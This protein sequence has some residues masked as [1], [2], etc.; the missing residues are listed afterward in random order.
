M[1]G[2]YCIT[3]GK[4]T[5]QLFPLGSFHARFLLPILF[6]FHL[7]KMVCFL[8]LLSLLFQPSTFSSYATFCLLKSVL[9][10]PTQP[11]PC[12]EIT[13]IANT[14]TPVIIVEMAVPISASNT[15][16]SP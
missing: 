13:L 15:T 12:A 9:I 16:P 6:D 11:D 10:F 8:S 7:E 4:I 14:N 2:H 3:K 5:V 1:Q